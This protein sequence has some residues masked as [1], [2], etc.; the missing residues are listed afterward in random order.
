M[1]VYVFVSVASFHL[2]H[3]PPAPPSTQRYAQP[4][5]CHT[6]PRTLHY[7][8]STATKL[9]QPH[10]YTTGVCDRLLEGLAEHQDLHLI[11]DGQDTGTGDTTENVGTCTLEERSDTFLGNDLATGIEG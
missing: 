3:H 2:P 8:L 6:P 4:V 1:C 10:V 7:R 9:A 11:V 5:Y